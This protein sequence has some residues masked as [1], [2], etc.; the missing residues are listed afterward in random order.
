MRFTPVPPKMPS[1]VD[2]AKD[3]EDYMYEKGLSVQ[4]LRELLAILEFSRRHD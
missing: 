1:S 3:L 4:D 2:K